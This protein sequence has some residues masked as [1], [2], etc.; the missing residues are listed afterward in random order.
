MIE[1]GTPA[2]RIAM[3]VLVFLA[4]LAIFL[5]IFSPMFGLVERRRRMAQVEELATAGR[6]D[7]SAASRSASPFARVAVSAA[8]Q[9]VR[10]RGWEERMSRQ[11]DRAGLK[12]RPSEWLL[13]R[14]G[15]ALGLAVVLTLLLGPLGFPLGA[16]LGVLATALFHR[17]LAGRRDDRFAAAL[18]DAIQMVIG[19]LRSGFSLQQ[20]LDAMVRESVDPL[21]GEFSRA[22]AEARLGME[23]EEAL[24][25]VAKR[26]NNK[27]LAWTVI[28]IRVQRE[29]GGNL[30][31]VLSTTISTIRERELLRGHVRALSAEGRLSAWVLLALPIVL[32][33]FM[34]LTRR[35]YVAPLLTDPRG[36]L[37][38]LAGVVLVVLGGFWLTR[39]VRVE[40]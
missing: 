25:R 31:E 30:A 2:F 40:V 8:E 27:D 23:L 20:A 7:R 36:I 32:G 4:L 22:L 5:L 1:T 21:A 37:L 3:A 34:F 15:V 10:T 28:A 26:M 6:A 11:L 29:V 13:V 12:L 17:H 14:I 9:V 33:A 18:P 39:V 35:E 19:S 16:V 24:D 38:L